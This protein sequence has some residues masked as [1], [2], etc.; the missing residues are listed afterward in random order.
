M[1]NTVNNLTKMKSQ[2]KTKYYLLVLILFGIGLC[3]YRAGYFGGIA[4][5]RDATQQSPVN[6]KQA[7]LVMRNPVAKR[8]MLSD[9]R[10]SK[11]DRTAIN[12]AFWKRKVAPLTY[13]SL[14]DYAGG[15]NA[16]SIKD[17][18][19]TEE[20][21][22]RINQI[23]DECL[24]SIGR[25]DTAHLVLAP[26]ADPKKISGM[27]EPY[28]E[29]GGAIADKFSSGLADILGPERY[30]QFSATYGGVEFDDIAGAGTLSKQFTV[31]VDAEGNYIFHL[32]KEMGMPDEVMDP[33]TPIMNSVTKTKDFA[34]LRYYGLYLN[35]Q[36][37][38]G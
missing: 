8:V 28:P 19:L 11:E 25:L 36:P 13:D 17:F 3:V 21:C 16:A 38:H 20:E 10:L 26:S 35:L 18:K 2:R 15:I 24:E 30:G 27:I 6:P 29:E 33:S 9:G 7:S 37:P 5:S 12:Q 22:R 1:G 4:A 31:E 23:R 34:E 32:T 14:W